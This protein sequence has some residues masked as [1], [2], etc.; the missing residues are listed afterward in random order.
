MGHPL[1]GGGRY[2][3]KLSRPSRSCLRFQRKEQQGLRHL[4]KDGSEEGV[5]GEELERSS[6]WCV[7]V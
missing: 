4:L 7:C 2:S 3:G 5:L 1:W 6:L